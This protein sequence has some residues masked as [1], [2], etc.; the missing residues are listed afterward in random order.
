MSRTKDAKKWNSGEPVRISRI[1]TSLNTGVRCDSANNTLEMRETAG[2]V[3][4][5]ENTYWSEDFTFPDKRALLL[6]PAGSGNIVDMLAPSTGASVQTTGR[7]NKDVR[8]N[9]RFNVIAGSNNAGKVRATEND[10]GDVYLQLA[11]SSTDSPVRYRYHAT[12]LASLVPVTGDGNSTARATNIK[13]LIDDADDDGFTANTSSRRRT[14]VFRAGNGTQF[15]KEIAGAVSGSNLLEA[16]PNPANGEV[17]INFIVPVQGFV[18][19][20]LYNT[21]GQK[22]TDITNGMFN[23]DRYSASFNVS[24]LP[25][26]TY[27][28][29]LSNEL[30]TKSTSIVVTK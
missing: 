21:L 5:N 18:S 28:V 14:G 17:T 1:L 19:V 13:A 10:K 6:G 9:I 8:G 2:Y 3:I 22:V 25:S 24:D 23:A 7:Q 4:G 15:T 27:Q 30:F 20:D 29:R 26:G 16:Y 12:T 11:A